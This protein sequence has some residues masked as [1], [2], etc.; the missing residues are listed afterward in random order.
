MSITAVR[1][2]VSLA[3]TTIALALLIEKTLMMGVFLIYFLN[4]FQNQT[5][6][7]TLGWAL[8]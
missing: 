3:L 2:V 8:D 5:Q 4:S 7:F 6:L 1:L